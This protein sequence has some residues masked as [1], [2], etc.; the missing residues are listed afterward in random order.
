[1]FALGCPAPSESGEP[2]AEISKSLTPYRGF[3]PSKDAFLRDPETL[4]VIVEDGTMYEFYTE[5]K[6]RYY[7]VDETTF[8]QYKGN[9]QA[10]AGAP[11]IEAT[12]SPL[13]PRELSSSKLT[14]TRRSTQPGIAFPQ[15]DDLI[16][17]LPTGAYFYWNQLG[18]RARSR[19][20]AVLKVTRT[21]GLPGFE[22]RAANVK[23]L[24]SSDQTW[25]TSAMYFMEHADVIASRHASLAVD[26]EA[27]N[28]Q[29]VP[30]PDVG[31]ALLYLNLALLG[32]NDH[33]VDLNAAGVPRPSVVGLRNM[34]FVS[35]STGGSEQPSSTR[36]EPR[37]VFLVFDFT[38]LGFGS[39]G[40]YGSFVE[41][42][43]KPLLTDNDLPTGK[44]VAT[45]LL[46]VLGNYDNAVS[47]IQA[48]RSRVFTDQ[49]LKDLNTYIRKVCSHSLSTHP[50][51][52]QFK[53]EIAAR[54]KRF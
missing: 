32:D 23:L 40:N 21:L 45:A 31:L 9:Q 25:Q 29:G 43:L 51:L 4:H 11:Y 10:L 7:F 27:L 35:T 30:A 39:G 48:N 18:K 49:T 12:T 8:E 13:A 42:S 41:S 50:K 28:P 37:G 5:R 52:A 54:C 34:F 2:R 46:T 53:S 38:P 16:L 36:C 44:A 26:T 1:M 19:E 22:A 3:I 6:L 20:V 17:L 14:I 47:L 24:R 15:T 33:R